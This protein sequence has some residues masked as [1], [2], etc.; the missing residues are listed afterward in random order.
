MRAVALVWSLVYIQDHTDTW[1]KAA[2]VQLV[3]TIGHLRSTEATRL[4]LSLSV[5]PL[6]GTN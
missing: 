3:L 4:R 2:E 1:P 6:I 5:T